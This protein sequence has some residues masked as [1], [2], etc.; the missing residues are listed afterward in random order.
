MTDS[1]NRASSRAAILCNAQVSVT[2][3]AAQHQEL[4]R[5]PRHILRRS[6][7]LGI[8][9][10]QASALSSP[11]P[12]SAT[13]GKC[14]DKRGTAH[15]HSP[16]KDSPRLVARG[17]SRA[18]RGQGRFA[19]RT[20]AALVAGRVRVGRTH[21]ETLHG[22][23]RSIQIGH[24]GRFDDRRDRPLRPTGNGGRALSSVVNAIRKAGPSRRECPTLPCP[25]DCSLW[26]AGA[27]S[28]APF[29]QPGFLGQRW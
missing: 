23:G 6:A 15:I 18:D 4:C 25:L 24:S 17:R 8:S 29:F 27:S 13:A 19:A 5:D 16:T 22:G 20:M 28:A 2:A 21:C 11:K 26:A 7:G 14:S 12:P 10:D 1:H 3:A 9:R